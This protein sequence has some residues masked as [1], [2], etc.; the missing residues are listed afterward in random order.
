MISLSLDHLAIIWRTPF[1]HF[2]VKERAPGKLLLNIRFLK[3][4]RKSKFIQRKR[5][6][7]D[8]ATGHIGPSNNAHAQEGS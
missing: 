1:F 2:W 8:W 5:D 6:E 4:V 7:M 3:E